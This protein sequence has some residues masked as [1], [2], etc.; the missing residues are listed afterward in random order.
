MSRQCS[1]V[2]PVLLE[3]SLISCLSPAEWGEEQSTSHASNP[4]RVLHSTPRFQRRTIGSAPVP[5]S[6]PQ[7]SI[8]A[9]CKAPCN[10]LRQGS[11]TPSSFSMAALLQASQTSDDSTQCD[12]TLQVHPSC[13]HK[14]VVS[15][16]VR[17]TSGGHN[18]QEGMCEAFSTA[19]ALL[20]RRERA[21][22]SRPRR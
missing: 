4:D 8:G 3:A 17:G 14:D 13:R 20:Q 6:S 15:S 21:H 5:I 1:H 12:L 7:Y 19:C 2:D 22:P 16:M 10:E 18:K 9:S 11:A